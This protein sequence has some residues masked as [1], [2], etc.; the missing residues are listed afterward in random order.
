[1]ATLSRLSAQFLDRLRGLETLR[2]FNRTS[3]QTQHIESTT[4]DFVKRPWLYLKWRFSLLP[5]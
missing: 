1:M 2:L 4:E 5:C 3:E